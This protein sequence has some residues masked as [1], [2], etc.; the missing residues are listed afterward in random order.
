MRN[1]SECFCHIRK[2][3]AMLLSLIADALRYVGLFLRPS[4]ALA[5]KNLFLHQQLALN[6]A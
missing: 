3:A 6:A 1:V 2:Q 4:P 5:A